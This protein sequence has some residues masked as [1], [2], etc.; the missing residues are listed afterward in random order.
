MHWEELCRELET[1]IWGTAYKII[2]KKNGIFTP[3]PTLE[4]KMEIATE[5]F[6]QGNKLLENNEKTQVTPFNAAELER[7]LKRLR[8]RK[9]AGP[10]GIP[11]EVIKEINREGSTKCDTKNV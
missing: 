9:A 7:G 2:T 6:P 3:A 5:L 10:D 8:S 11:P 4:R 1:D